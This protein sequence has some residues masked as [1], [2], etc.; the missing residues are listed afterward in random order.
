MSRRTRCCLSGDIGCS[1]G[2]NDGIDV[3]D[4]DL[5][6]M[7]LGLYAFGLEVEASEFHADFFQLIVFLGEFALK[8]GVV[9]IAFLEFVLEAFGFLFELG[10]FLHCGGFALPGFWRGRSSICRGGPSRFALAERAVLRRPSSSSWVLWPWVVLRAFSREP[11]LSSSSFILLSLIS[12][13]LRASR[14]RPEFVAKIGEVV[15]ESIAEGFHFI[16]SGSL[17]FLVPLHFAEFPCGLGELGIEL[18]D[19][20]A[21]IWDFRAILELL[22]FP[23]EFW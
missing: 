11:T 12:A 5:K 4:A 19:F 20:L 2:I 8:F 9:A 13:A 17:I 7:H 18:F 10:G 23:L 14:S 1:F 21:L 6:G 16:G 15:L 3:C 22:V